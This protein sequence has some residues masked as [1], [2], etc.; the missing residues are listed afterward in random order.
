VAGVLRSD[1][2][3]SDL[4]HCSS[5]RQSA[6]RLGLPDAVIRPEKSLQVNDLNPVIGLQY[7]VSPKID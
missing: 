7:F 5:S 1:E 3:I 2:V 4:L 6:G